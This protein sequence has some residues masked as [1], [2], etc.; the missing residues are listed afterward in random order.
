MTE[1]DA[2]DAAADRAGAG[3]SA[4][5]EP[6]AA[7]RHADAAPERAPA[8]R[9]LRRALSPRL[10]TSRLV[11]AL[12]CALLGFA[13]VVQVQQ[14]Q[15]E[16][17]SSLRQSELVRILDEVTQRGSD[18]ENEVRTLREQ[19]DELQSGTADDAAALAV[20][21]ERAERQGILSGRLPAVGTGVTV[22]IT[23]GDTPLRATV[24]LTVLEEL[25]NAGAEVIELNGV[26]LV[27]SSYLVET[28]EGIVVDGQVVSAPYLWAAIGDPS[29]LGPALEIPGGAMSSVRTGGATGRIE[30]VD[31]LEINAVREPAPLRYAEPV[32]G[33]DTA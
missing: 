19:R 7:P 30:A 12:L 21:V 32:T 1:P 2:T 22:R 15:T 18:L 26:R 14:T 29:A 13:L 27:A 17:L 4:T 16:S 10:S 5:P 11:A 24:L 3:H 8:W 33:T 23:E 28:N 25:R 9:T 6:G 31:E 20:A